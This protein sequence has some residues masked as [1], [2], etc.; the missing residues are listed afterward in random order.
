MAFSKQGSNVA[1]VDIN[2]DTAT[3]T[4]ES[5][6]GKNGKESHSII[7]QWNLSCP[8]P[9][10]LGQRGYVRDHYLNITSPMQ[11]SLI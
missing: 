6:E 9:H 11:F 1:V 8:W 7:L 5:L 10:S 3:Q 4:L 2:G